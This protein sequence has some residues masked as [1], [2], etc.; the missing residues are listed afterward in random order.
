MSTD[1]AELDQQAPI[2]PAAPPAEMRA[3]RLQFPRRIVMLIL[4]FLGAQLFIYLLRVFAPVGRLIGIEPGDIAGDIWSRSLVTGHP[5]WEVVRAGLFN[6]ILLWI[7]ATLAALALAALPAL[8]GVLADRL[9]RDR[10]WPGSVVKGLGRLWIFSSTAIP[11]AALGLAL[12]F[13]FPVGLRFLASGGIRTPRGD[14]Q[15]EALILP[16]IIVA[17]YPSLLIGQAFA[18]QATMPRGNRRWLSASVQALGALDGQS[19]GILS[20]VLLVEVLF[21]WPGLGRTLMQAVATLDLPVMF[22]VL[23]AL[24]VMVLVG[25]MFAELW[26][27]LARLAAGTT[28]APESRTPWQWQARRIWTAVGLIALLIPLAI[29]LYG[30]LLPGDAATVMDL[31]GRN[32]APSLEHYFGTDELGRDQFVRS[33][34]GAARALTQAVVVSALALLPAAVPG[35]L[36]GYFDT[37]RTWQ[38]ESG[39]DAVRLLFSPLLLIPLLPGVAVIAVVFFRAGMLMVGLLLALFLLPR[40]IN[41][42][43]V[44][45]RA[46]P[47]TRS[48]VMRILLGLAALFLGLSYAAFAA[49]L[50]LNYFGIGVNPPTP[51]LGESLRN[52]QMTLFVNPASTFGVIAVVA[53]C[54]ITLYLAADALLGWFDTKEAMV[55]LNE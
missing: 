7:T 19:A 18:R 4:T 29:A 21:N 13:V 53:L 10:A 46:G 41:A 32:S 14:L 24:T 48:P 49:I 1:Q 36:V 31:R 28:I 55:R 11:V 6:T 34:K 51:S 23:T 9:E 33:M 54:A 44:L 12:L 25:R 20:A 35:I 47:D 27:W 26:R 2:E 42:W 50:A 22:G 43:A 8:V 16:T 38:F 39:A 37:R 45:W 52:A 40:A 30:W 17:L 3:I 15:L 5:V